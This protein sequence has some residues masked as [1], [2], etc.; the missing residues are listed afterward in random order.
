MLSQE[1]YQKRRRQLIE[2]L[3]EGVVILPGYAERILSND[4]NHKFR[5]QSEIIYYSG[6]PEPDTTVLIE[7]DG[8]KLSYHLFV[9][10]RDPAKE[11]YDGKRYGTD[12][13]KE[14]FKA[15][16]TYTIDKLEDQL[17]LILAKYEKVYFQ[18]GENLEIDK[19]VYRS[20]TTAVNSKNR[21]GKGP[22]NLINPIDTYHQIRSVKSDGEIQ[23][24][25]SAA[26]ISS[27]AITK[28]M[29]YTKPGI[30]EYQI[31]A[32]IDFEFRNSGAQ[33]P[34]YQSI[35]GNGANATILHYVE[36][37]QELQDGKLILVDAGA[38]YEDYCADIT[39]TWPVNGKFSDPQK[40]VY[41][42][43]L[44]V[45]KDCIA[46][47]KPGVK[48]WDI[49]NHAIEQLTRGL[50]ELGIL[51]GEVD[52]LIENKDYRRFYMHSLGHWVGLDVHDTSRFRTDQ[53]I[54]K[55][56]LY[57]TIEPGIY[58]PDEEDIPS[59][60]RGIGVRIEDDVLV[61]ETG[62]RV[63]TANVVKEIEDIEAIVGTE[64][65]NY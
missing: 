12:G 54:L 48:F 27:Q 20:I 19:I 10:N 31:E 4:T 51:E 3:G 35:C 63:L 37:N 61:T 11:T 38:Q 65:K 21:K 59:E 52:K 49:N 57:V 53:E 55:P 13:A 40:R 34:A 1:V 42:L 50:I 9:R 41:Q 29:K 32:L 62:N 6:F 64:V 33:R 26:E 45:Q 43:V 7:Y 2:I 36:N 30:N 56:G 25:E 8:K 15:D 18:G 60:F 23:I 39:R 28:A 17:V 5:Q 46:R 47:V 14:I 16:S 44:K 24:C 22:V 58:I